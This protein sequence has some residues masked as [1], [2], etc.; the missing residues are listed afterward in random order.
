MGWE[1]H[2]PGGPPPKQ[3][4]FGICGNI[5]PLFAN[6]VFQLP[7]GTQRTFGV[8]I[9][10]YYGYEKSKLYLFR[11]SYENRPEMDWGQGGALLGHHD[12]D[13]LRLLR[14]STPC[15]LLSNLLELEV[16]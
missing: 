4:P 9:P 15:K 7:P 12:P 6:D 13:A 5:N 8:A 2:E 3:V 1:I 11:L 14:R 16:K 10:D